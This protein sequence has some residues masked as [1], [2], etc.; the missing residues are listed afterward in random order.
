[1]LLVT[2]VAVGYVAVLVRRVSFVAAAGNLSSVE[3]LIE[4]CLNVFAVLL[5]ATG[6]GAVWLFGLHG[7]GRAY[8]PVRF[9]TAITVTAFVISCTKSLV[10][11][12]QSG[13][14]A[15]SRCLGAL[16]PIFVRLRLS[17]RR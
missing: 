14:L 17:R 5:V 1:M 4:V 10:T 2:T 9:F 6:F 11:A 7:L 16:V 8:F 12:D 3:C 13:V 15:T